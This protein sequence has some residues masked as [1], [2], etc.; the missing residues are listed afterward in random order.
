M[1]SKPPLI[2]LLG[3][4]PLM[5]AA[6]DASDKSQA[7]AMPPPAVKTL[8][9]VPEDVPI[10]KEYPGR[11]APIRLAE[12][13]ARVS[14]IVLARKFVEGSDVTAG[15]VL[16]EIDRA[17]FKAMVASA[18]AQ[19]ARAEAALLLAAQQ[20]DRVQR[21]L[22]TNAASKDR[23]DT[24]LAARK[25]AEAEVALAK[26]NLQSAELDLSYA[27]VRSPIS[28]RI[29]S[30]L[31]TEG[32]LARQEDGTQ[33]AIIRDLS[34]VYVDFTAPLADLENLNEEFAGKLNGQP[35]SEGA[36]ELVMNDGS[37]HAL[38]GRLLFTSAAVNESTGQVALRAEFAN[39]EG[40]LLPG[41]YVRVRMTQGIARSALLVPHRA[42]QWDTL[43]QARVMTVREGLAHLQPVTTAHSVNSRWLITE[44]LKP[45]DSVIIDGQAR[46]IPGRPVSA[47][48]VSQQNPT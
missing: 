24:V 19:L 33:M 22:V 11:L 28:G 31:V 41:S 43:G 48:P 29:G 3:L 35:A 34:S 8:A 25:Q 30:A 16:F 32:A 18:K 27:S 26:A 4:A 38:R 17:K 42:V 39:A 13:R 9:L 40:K 10:L 37:V 15:D 21:L 6:C 20:T 7:A 5:L 46:A 36:V 44:G 23:F 45:G 47:E 1:R 2:L 12:V 14:G